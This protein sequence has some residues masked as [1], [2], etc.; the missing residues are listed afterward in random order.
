[1]TKNGRVVNI[2]V[3]G[4]GP[5]AV[6]WVEFHRDALDWHN[7]RHVMHHAG[8]ISQASLE[9]ARRAQKQIE[10]KRAQDVAADVAA[11]KAAFRNWPVDGVVKVGVADKATA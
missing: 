2:V 1:M 4:V 11:L 10:A 6:V 5:K 8:H 9:R 3:D 7:V